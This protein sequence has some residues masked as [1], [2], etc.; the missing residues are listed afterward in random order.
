LTEA[1][2]PGISLHG[3]DKRL[4]WA[5]VAIVALTAAVYAP[6]LGHGYINYDDTDYVVDNPALRGGLRPST[7]LWALR[8]VEHMNWHPLTWLSHALDWQLFGARWGGHHAS[9]L[10][11]HIATV[12]AVFLAL[13]S[14]TRAPGRSLAV[15]ALFAVHPINVQS[16]AWLAERKNVLSGLLFALT[17]AAYASYARRPTALRYAT[18][19]A[20][21]ALG[22]MAKPMLVTTPMVL[23][24]LDVW[25]LARIPPWHR[26]VLLEKVPWLAM[27]AA[28]SVLTLHA[29]TDALEPLADGSVASRVCAALGGYLGYLEKI[30]WPAQFAILYPKPSA[31]CWTLPVGAAAGLLFALTA[32]AVM[33]VRRRPYLMVGWLWFVGTL[34]PVSGLVQVGLQLMADRYAYLP[35]LGLLLA[36][37]WAAA[38]LAPGAR[39]RAAAATLTVALVAALA[40]RTSIELRYWKDGLTLFSRAIAITDDNCVAYNSAALE[41]R[42]Q[43]QIEAAWRHFERAIAA[44]PRLDIAHANL[45][46]LMLEVGQLDRALPHLAAAA[47][48]NPRRAN[49]QYNLGVALWY[50]GRAAEA[51]RAMERALQA[52]PRHAEA[53]AMMERIRGRSPASP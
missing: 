37:V 24:L 43:K 47:E 29:Q 22:L 1:G 8:S 40:W 38:D 42:R 5:V 46:S 18:V 50:K 2:S 31:P 20:T 7:V 39:G 9:S 16:V 48:L 27:A 15:A 44:C 35:M 21:F 49:A 14:L 30:S 53:R 32:L 45:A 11:L 3:Q 33:T 52:D 23:L 51:A 10:A 13:R 19:T 17:L 6:V 4:A 34:V 12:L 25:P 28:S 26:R 36:V 41:L